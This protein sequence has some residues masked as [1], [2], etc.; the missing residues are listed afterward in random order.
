MLCFLFVDYHSGDSRRRPQHVRACY[1]VVYVS[2]YLM[3][4]FWNKHYKIYLVAWNVDDIKVVG[5]DI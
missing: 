2:I 3:Y 5:L 1:M 4:S